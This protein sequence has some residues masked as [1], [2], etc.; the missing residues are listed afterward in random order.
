M[1]ESPFTEQSIPRTSGN[2]ILVGATSGQ[3]RQSTAA[4]WSSGYSQ[5]SGLDLSPSK[6]K[7]A[8]GEA[9][10]AE[11]GVSLVLPERNGTGRGFAVT[12]KLQVSERRDR[13]CVFP[14][15]FSLLVSLER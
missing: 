10:S 1:I 3:G 2:A 8:S 14:L 4:V 15:K 13:I 6:M 7:A 12:K 9:F 5:S 11:T